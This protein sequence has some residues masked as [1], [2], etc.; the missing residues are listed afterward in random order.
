MNTPQIAYISLGTNLGDK[1]LNLQQAIGE[2]HLNAGEVVGIS[3]VYQTPSWGFE[4][5]TFFNAALKILTRLSPKELLEALLAIETTLGRRRS[6]PKGYENRLIDLDILFYSDTIVNEH[7]LKIP[8]PTLQDRRFVLQPM[9]DLDESLNH[10]AFD[11]SIVELLEE[12]TDKDPIEEVEVILESSKNSCSLTQFRYLAIEGN[13]GSG[14]TSL[15]TMIAQDYNAKLVLE[16]FKDNP[17]LPKFYENASRFAFPLEM[18]F[19]ADRYQQL[20]D[21][22]AQYDL[23]KD[24]IVSDY[25]VFK[26]LI[27][28]KITLAED[29]YSLYKTLFDIIHKDLVKPD[30]Y[31]YLYQ[32][33]ERLL[34][35]IKKRG[36][37][38]E[39]NIQ[40]EYLEKINKNYLAYIKSKQDANVKIIDVSALDFV[41]KRKDYLA[42]LEEIG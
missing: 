22:L 36:R 1:A 6:T 37:Q 32:N 33:T 35:N 15:A 8:H 41:A 26:S 12:T 31:V 11:M 38:Y 18:S 7:Y 17:F 24:F 23:F 10:P 39:Q 4:G 5:H 40:P 14:K 2:I 20:K 25:D 27:F 28:A 13:I 9:M 42:V 19:L 30:A 3:K 16:R 34:E 29:E 21:E